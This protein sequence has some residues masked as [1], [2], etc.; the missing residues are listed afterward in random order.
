M[1]SSKAYLVNLVAAILLQ[2]AS[3]IAEQGNIKDGSRDQEQKR[4]DE[5]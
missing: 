2:I 4:T 1:Q 3:N 5:N